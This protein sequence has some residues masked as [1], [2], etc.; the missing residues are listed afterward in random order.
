MGDLID[1]AESAKR[2]HVREV[3]LDVFWIIL[4][5][6][7]PIP[8]FGE[9]H[10][11]QNS[12]YDDALASKHTAKTARIGAKSRLGGAICDRTDVFQPRYRKRAGGWKNPNSLA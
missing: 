4:R 3:F 10:S 1:C 7:F 12:G 11:R 6:A 9:H 8:P 5:L 2:A